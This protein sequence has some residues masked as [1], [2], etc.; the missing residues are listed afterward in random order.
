MTTNNSENT[1]WTDLKDFGLPH[2]EIKPLPNVKIKTVEVDDLKQK[3]EEVFKNSEQT[4]EEE[5]LDVLVAPILF[6]T[7]DPIQVDDLEQKEKEVLNN[8]E[9]II[10]EEVNETPIVFQTEELPA[11]DPVEVKPVQVF[12]EVQNPALSVESDKKLVFPAQNKPKKNK[13][14]IWIVIL[15]FLIIGGGVTFQF[16]QEIKQIIRPIIQKILEQNPF[17]NQPEQKTPIVPSEPEDS[18]SSA[19]QPIGKEDAN[20]DSI[21]LNNLQ[22]SNS[23]VGGSSL[24]NSESI[25]IERITSRVDKPRYF[26]VVGS[27]PS[28]RLAIKQAAVYVDRSPVL[29]LISPYGDISNYRLSIGYFDS[30]IDATSELERVKS[31]YTEALWILKY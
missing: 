2:V 26:I 28:E 18:N 21:P 27:L 5:I 17:T 15:L 7:N 8:S 12:E 13:A 24:T 20:S 16:Q 10:Q 25:K 14:W 19:V 4:I 31:K 29:Y 23:Q 3:E 1:H 30:L 11:P 6:E 22:E 9:S